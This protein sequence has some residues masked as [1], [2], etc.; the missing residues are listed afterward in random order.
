MSVS[1]DVGNVILSLQIVILFLLILGL[2]F[3]KGRDN[4]KNIARHGYL[5]ALALIFHTILVFVGMITS[6]NTNLEAIS[7]L[8]ILDSVI[9]WSHIILGIIAEI[10][11]FALVASWMFKSS[12]NMTCAKRNKWIDVRLYNMG[13]FFS[14][15]R[16]N[17]HSRNNIVNTEALN[18][19]FQH[20]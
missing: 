5:T 11:G 6:F 14:Q 10:L 20:Y 9:V 2:P 1:L 7:E 16:S 13:S 19:I 4:K 17:T 18:L 12:S 3:V 15:W 8:S